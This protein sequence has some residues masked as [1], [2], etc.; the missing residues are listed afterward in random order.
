MSDVKY[1]EPP[2]YNGV[3]QWVAVIAKN[4]DWLL[5]YIKSLQDNTLLDENGAE[6]EDEFQPTFFLD[7]TLYCDLVDDGVFYST[8]NEIE[9]KKYIK[10]KTDIAIDYKKESKKSNVDFSHY[11]FS[12]TCKCGNFIGFKHLREIPET[13]MQC[14]LCDR[15]LIEYT[16]NDIYDYTYHL[17]YYK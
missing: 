14:G 2:L 8:M 5:G 15:L 6:L 1:Y 7:S 16:G 4:R 12:I 3:H 10:E 9:R 13:N 17:G 11:Q